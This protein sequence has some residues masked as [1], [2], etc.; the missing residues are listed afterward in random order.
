MKAELVDLIKANM[1]DIRMLAVRLSLEELLVRK[2]EVGQVRLSRLYKT[3]TT[4]EEGGEAPE[5]IGGIEEFLANLSEDGI[6]VRPYA[7]RGSNAGGN[8]TSLQVTVTNMEL[9][10]IPWVDSDS[11]ISNRMGN[12]YADSHVCFVMGYMNDGDET[13]PLKTTSVF[14]TRR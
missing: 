9:H 6:E 11:E 4:V 7:V 12:A 14:L 5:P 13:L 1:E 8:V 10:F 2:K 3:G